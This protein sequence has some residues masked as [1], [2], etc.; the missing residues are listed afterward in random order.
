MT[1]VVPRSTPFTIAAFGVLVPGTLTG[2]ARVAAA[3]YV[4]ALS[5]APGAPR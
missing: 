2:A 5:P 1:A 3:V 4:G